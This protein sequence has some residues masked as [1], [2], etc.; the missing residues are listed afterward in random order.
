MKKFYLIIFLAIPIFGFTQSSYLKSIEKGKY[1]KL[2]KKIDKS[3]EKNPA[4]IELNYYKARLLMKSDYKNYNPKQSYK[5]LVDLKSSYRKVDEKE[6]KKLEKIPLNADVINRYI[7]TVCFRA[8]NDAIKL[9]KEEGYQDYLNYYTL[10]PTKYLNS[11]TENRNRVA[12]DNA[13]KVNTP[14]AFQQFMTK[15]PKAAQYSSAKSKRNALEFARAKTT[16]NIE[17]YKAFI[18]KYPD[19]DEANLAWERIHEIA[20]EEAKRINTAAA[21]KKY[22]QDYPN[23][24]LFN[25]AYII[26]EEKLFNET[27]NPSDWRSYQRFVVRNPKNSWNPVALDSLFYHAELLEDLESLKF[28]VDNMKGEK[29]LDALLKYYEIFTSDGD[30]ATLNLFYTEYYEEIFFERKIQDYKVAAAGLALGLDSPYKIGD[31]KS[32]EDYIKSASASDHAFVAVQRVISDYLNKKDWKSAILKLEYFKPLFYNRPDNLNDLIELLK[33][34]VDKSIVVNNIGYNINTTVGGEYVPVISADDKLIY[35]CGKNRKDNIGGE[36]IFVSQKTNGI[37]GPSKIISGLSTLFSNDAPISLSTDGTVLM[38]FKNGN[39]FFSEKKSN[40]WDTPVELSE[41]INSGSWQADAMITSD[42]KALIFTS[43][44]KGGYNLHENSNGY[45]GDNQYPADIWVSMRDSKG[46]WG[47]PINIGRTINTRYCERSPFLHPDMKTLYFSSDGH[48]GMGKLDVFKS[49]RLSDTCWTCWSEPINMGKEI[50]TADSDWGY[51]ISTDGEK[52]YFAKLPNGSEEY[53]IF[54][55]KLPDKLRP[56][57][58]ATVS[59]KLID[60]DSNPVSAEILWEDLESGKTVGQ[61]QSDPKDGS[62]FIVLPLGKIYG[63][64]VDKDEYFPISNNVDL[65]N[66]KKQVI[67]EENIDMVTFEQMVEFG[68]AVPVNNLFFNFGESTLLPYSLPE[69]KRVADIIKANNLKVEL[70][71]HTDNIGT[72]EDNLILSEERAIAVK[73]FLVNEGCPES[74]FTII[75]YGMTKPVE[76]ND[77]EQGRAK[78]RRVELKFVD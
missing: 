50:N 45:H 3:L 71:G 69:L 66:V 12:F 23:S 32:Y 55:L 21:F 64:Y 14:E 1:S 38:L 35:F 48:G 59:G 15:Y 54:W 46:D 25:K 11:A 27:T 19:A 36:D 13:C 70:S 5:I 18:A 40:G 76:K 52:A 6:R 20:F 63:Y 33:T 41:N 73:D 61:S 65:R 49:T 8:L 75:G 24:N 62:F 28:C 30:Y 2:E 39:L 34:P 51:K 78:N 7:D 43:T 22:T 17:S 42:G 53:D 58:V 57:M 60:K 16:D 47:I 44:R 10:T 26:Y 67:I 37:W 72:A 31:Y 29:K 68:T 77:T 4:D 74:L 9:D 56:D